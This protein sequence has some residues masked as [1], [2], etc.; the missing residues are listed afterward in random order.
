MCTRS[1]S[2]CRLIAILIVSL[3]RFF[4][5]KV[6][7]FEFKNVPGNFDFDVFD[8]DFA[9]LQILIDIQLNVNTI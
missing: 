4:G 5:A 8:S 1:F 7:L 6:V 2:R 9:T 3:L